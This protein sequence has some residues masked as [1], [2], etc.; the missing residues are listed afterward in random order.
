MKKERTA[1]RDFDLSHFEGNDWI[2]GVDEAGRG[3]LAGPVVAGVVLVSNAFYDGE[4]CAKMAR[5]IDD[6]K[7]LTPEKREKVFNTLPDLAAEHNAYFST[8]I[9]DAR[10]IDAINI[11]NATKLAMRRALEKIG[12]M[13]NDLVMLPL[14]GQNDDLFSKTDRAALF[15]QTTILVDGLPLKSFPYEHSAYVGGDGKSLAIGLASI[16]AKVTRDKLMRELDEKFPDYG[17]ALHK[18]YGTERHRA[19]LEKYGPCEL[20]RRTFLVKLSGNGEN[21][22]DDQSVFNLA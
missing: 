6:S 15:H 2:A 21:A 5:E 20:H 13:S 18:G 19:A 16:I 7:K 1:H 10:E 12:E 17:F 14:K 8:G 9:A 3:C 11:L 22:H 4:W